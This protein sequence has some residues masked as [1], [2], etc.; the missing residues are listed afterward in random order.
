AA[1]DVVAYDLLQTVLNALSN[2]KRVQN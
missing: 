1:E 2:F